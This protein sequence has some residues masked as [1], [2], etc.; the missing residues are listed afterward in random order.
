MPMTQMPLLQ[1]TAWSVAQVTRY[2]K[3]LLESD[4]NLADLWV[5]GEISNFAQP[6]SGHLYFT[7][8]D[9]SASI[10]LYRTSGG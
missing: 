6:R 8:K 5:Q 10:K 1:P 9:A 4:H 3:E 7:I 2:L